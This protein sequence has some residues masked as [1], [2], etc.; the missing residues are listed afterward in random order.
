MVV[1][2]GLLVVEK[3]LVSLVNDNVVACSDLTFKEEPAIVVN[4]LKVQAQE[5]SEVAVDFLVDTLEE[6][7]RKD[8][9]EVLGPV[10]LILEHKH[11]GDDSALAHTGWDTQELAPTLGVAESRDCGGKL[12]V[13]DTVVDLLEDASDPLLLLDELLKLSFR[14]FDAH[15]FQLELD[16]V[17]VC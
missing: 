17:A 10:I 6:S 9:G 16:T 2:Q 11:S 15:L 7:S 13:V 12:V 3:Y 14:Q 5:A 1:W 4:E 8:Y